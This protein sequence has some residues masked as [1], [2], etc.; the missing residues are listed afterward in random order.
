[1][2]V[3]NVPAEKFEAAIEPLKKEFPA[4]KLSNEPLCLGRGT[5][6]YRDEYSKKCEGPCQPIDFA[7]D[8]AP[9]HEE[10]RNPTT[11]HDHVDVRM[12]GHRGAP[13]ISATPR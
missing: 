10:Q 5:A 8:Y 12:M 7:H 3:A 2:R 13:G 6:P 1:M 11:R 4:G 9:H